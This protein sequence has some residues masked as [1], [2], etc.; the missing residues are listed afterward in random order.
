MEYAIAKMSTKGQLVIPLA[1]RKEIKAGDSFLLIKDETRFI[2]KN[3][4][5]LAA[6][7]QDDFDFA[8]KTEKAW[9]DYDSG[10][11]VTRT[12]EEFLK[13]LRSC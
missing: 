12:K 11:F 4:K 2:L 6:E 9:R 7:L 13:E 3:L 8:E 1:L 5:T 10:K